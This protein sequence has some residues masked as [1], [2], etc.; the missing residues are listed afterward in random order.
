MAVVTC[1]PRDRETWHVGKSK[2]EDVFY[3][4]SVNSTEVLTGSALVSYIRGR[5]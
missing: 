5:W 3:Y 2:V 4:R 1:S